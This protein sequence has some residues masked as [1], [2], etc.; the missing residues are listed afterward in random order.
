MAYYTASCEGKYS[1][2]GVSFPCDKSCCSGKIG[3]LRSHEQYELSLKHGHTE[4][5]ITKLHTM[6]NSSDWDQHLF[7]ESLIKEYGKL[8]K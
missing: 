7:A 1:E 3:S 5:L 4:E 8:I 2:F 6:Y